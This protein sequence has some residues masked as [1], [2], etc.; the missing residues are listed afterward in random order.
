MHGERHLESRDARMCMTYSY[1][2]V[3]FHYT[4][5]LTGFINLL[6]ITEWILVFQTSHDLQTFMCTPYE[7]RIHLERDNQSLSVMSRH[8]QRSTRLQK[9]RTEVY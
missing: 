1:E 7:E 3:N 9:C 4:C 5:S 8:K 6:G 2:I